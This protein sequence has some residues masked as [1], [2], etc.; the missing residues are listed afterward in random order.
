MRVDLDINSKDDLEKLI[1]AQINHA[2]GEIEE[3]QP[4]ESEGENI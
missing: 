3:I 4:E 1:E 2:L